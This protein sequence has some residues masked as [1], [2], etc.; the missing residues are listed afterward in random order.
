MIDTIMFDLDGTLLPMDQI[1]FVNSYMKHLVGRFAPQGFDGEMIVK[2]L[3]AGVKAMMENDGSMTN[4]ERFWQTFLQFVPDEEHVFRDQIEDFYR[5]E[6]DLV[7]EVVHDN[8]ITRKLIDDLQQKGYKLILA[9]NPL[10]PPCAIE[11][12]LAGPKGAR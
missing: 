12:R 2:G 7:Q 3:W 4:E 9:T 6:F 8:G 10:F 1:E 11:T 5:N